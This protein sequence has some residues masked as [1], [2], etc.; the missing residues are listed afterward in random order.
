MKGPLP[1]SKSRFADRG[2]AAE[3]AVKKA[4]DAWADESPHREANRLV[5]TKAAGRTI[6]AAPAD[7]EF[8]CLHEGVACHGLIEVKETQHEYRLDRSRLTQQARL[9]RRAKCGGFTFVLVYHST[10]GVWRCMSSADLGEPSTKGS[11]D[12][13]ELPTFKGPREALSAKTSGVVWGD[14][15]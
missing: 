10:S 12:L 7:F 1:F 9:R 8:F 4:L 13:R 6:K 3:S 14:F 2:S 5:D 15:R 11:W